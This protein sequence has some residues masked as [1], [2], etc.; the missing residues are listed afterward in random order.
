MRTIRFKSRSPRRCSSVTCQ[1]GFGQVSP[2]AVHEEVHVGHLAKQAAACSG[3]VTSQAITRPPAATPPPRQRF[4]APATE[5]QPRGTGFREGLGARPADPA[6]GAHH[7]H[8]L[9]SRRKVERTDG[10]GRDPSAERRMG[11]GLMADPPPGWISKCRWVAPPRALPSPP[12]PWS[13]HAPT[14]APRGDP[15]CCSGARSSSFGR[16]YPEAR[17]WSRRQRP[18]PVLEMVPETTATTALAGSHDVVP[19]WLRPPEREKPQS[20]MCRSVVRRRGTPSRCGRWSTVR[21][22]PGG[23][24]RRDPRAVEVPGE[25]RALRAAT[26]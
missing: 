10:S 11:Y 12:C 17:S 20:L 23:R 26:T 4:A 8:D 13:A 19:W 15:Q 7:H 2:G 25:V 3:R 22:V 24:A 1:E 18:Y 6:A 21:P 5:H 16:P 14:E 9:A